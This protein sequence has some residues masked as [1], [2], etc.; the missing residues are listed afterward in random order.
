MYIDDNEIK[1]IV[2]DKDT[3]EF[4]GKRMNKACAIEYIK[5]L[6]EEIGIKVFNELE[7]DQAVETAYEE[8]FEAVHERN[9]D[10]GYNDGIEHAKKRR[11]KV[12]NKYQCVNCNRELSD[13]EVKRHSDRV[14]PAIDV[15]DIAKTVFAL[16]DYNDNCKK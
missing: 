14:T 4:N 1:V 3:V 12:A 9:Y 8:G 7:L 11:D 15:N 13:E 10:E 5:I 6:A 2:I 16:S